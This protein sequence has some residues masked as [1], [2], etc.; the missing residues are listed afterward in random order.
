MNNSSWTML[1]T[2]AAVGAGVMYLLDPRGGARRR[3]LIRDQVVHASHKTGDALDALAHDAANRAKGLA[4]ETASAFSRQSVSA[5]QLQERVRA[6]LGRVVSHPRAID[7]H[8][9]EDGVVTLAGPMLSDEAHGALTA[10]GRVRGVSAVEDRLERHDTA[11]GVPSLQGGRRR[12]DQ[13]GS[14]LSGSWSPTARAFMLGSTALAVGLGYA[15][16][17]TQHRA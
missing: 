11:E 8:T 13:P 9:S 3:A 10:I 5:R 15:T 17:G 1:A 12:P 6:E 14:W 16:L 2:G 7:V 4:A